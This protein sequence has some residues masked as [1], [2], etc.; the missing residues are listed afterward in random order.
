[1]AHV[2]R[3]H[4]KPCDREGCGDGFAKHGRS[5]KGACTRE[6]CVC[7][8]WRPAEGDR[9]TLRARWR[10]PAG[11]E[12]SKTFTRKIDA[13]R[14]LV[15]VED[16][17]L[18][19]AY[20]DPAA[21]RTLF[22]PWAERWY[23]S[24]A[25]LKP[26]TRRDYRKLLDQQVLPRFRDMPLAAIDTLAVEEWLSRV[27]AGDP[28]ADP[29]RAAIGAKRAGKAL[30]VLSQ[31][32]GAAVKG[33]R[34]TVNHAAGVAK[35]KGQ[36]REM[37]FLD[38]AQVERLAEA[39]R[40][41]YGVM[42][43]FAAYTGLRPCELTALRVGR[44]DLLAGTARICEAA[45][46]VDGKLHWG[47]VKTHEARTVRLPRFLAEELGAHLADRP[48]DPEALMFPAPLGGPLRFSKWTDNYYKRA[49]PVANQAIIAAA[50]P[51][52]RPALLSPS[53]RVYDLRHTCASLLIAEGASIKAVQAQM[54]HKTATMTLDLYGH[55]FPDET[56]R[57]A[58]RMDRAR[59]ATVSRLSRTQ[60]GPVVVPISK[61][62]GQEA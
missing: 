26:T 54:G 43:R 18:R 10:D 15:S 12:R 47:G 16:S 24:T 17:K 40:G 53:L 58:E 14:F 49:I 52:E 61:A 7:P 2:E 3:H 28:K 57:L 11:R 55:L 39:V 13:D 27:L 38:L 6:G 5:A 59:E 44:V 35:P 29:P 37:H 4:R 62:A 36:R 21:G 41:P 46:E 8:R 51:G 48:H 60:G 30:Q 45:P 34:L 9:E 50:K 56:E 31:A 42:I 20:V 33:K 19:G 22:G 1:M 32:L 25:H 23:N